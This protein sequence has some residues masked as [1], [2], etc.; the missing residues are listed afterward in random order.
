[1][2]EGLQTRMNCPQVNTGAITPYFK[3]ALILTDR[4][5]GIQPRIPPYPTT[6]PS[7]ES[8]HSSM[9]HYTRKT[10]GVP[11]TRQVQQARSRIILSQTCREL[12]QPSVSHPLNPSSW[13]RE[14]VTEH[15]TSPHMAMTQ[16]L[17][18]Y[19]TFRQRRSPV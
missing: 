9:L 8:L 3:V 10:R 15:N 5:S 17:L 18:S 16:S 19:S 14:C 6:D 1:M 13:L 2:F 4:L 12:V 11:S 7:N